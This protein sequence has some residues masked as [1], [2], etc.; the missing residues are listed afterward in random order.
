MQECVT[1]SVTQAEYVSAADC[2]QE[3]LFQKHVLESIGLQVELPMI[4]EVD[5][6][7][8]ID[9]ANNWS[10]SGRTR[11]VDVKHH[12]LRELKEQG[13]IRLQ[14]ISTKDNSSDLY[15][16]NLDGETFA[17]HAMVYCSDPELKEEGVGGASRDKSG[18]SGGNRQELSDHRHEEF[19]SSATMMAKEFESMAHCKVP[20]S[21]Q[22]ELASDM[23]GDVAYE[24]VQ[25]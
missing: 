20:M 12:F 1:T 3:M 24:V 14:W 19:S 23:G 4:L 21:E 25:L 13:I 22:A 18:L 8:A 7:G 6:K 5:N 11:H 10:A 9:L 16:K 15:T 17:S 2:V